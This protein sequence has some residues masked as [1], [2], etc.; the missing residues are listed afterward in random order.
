MRRSPRL[1]VVFTNYRLA[2]PMDPL[3]FSIANVLVGNKATIEGLEITLNGPELAFLGEAVVS[4]CGAPMEFTIDGKDCPMWSRIRVNA[5][6]RM[7]IGK[8]TGGGC[9]SYL[10]VHGGLPGVAE[11]FGSKATSPGVGV[12]GYQGRQLASGDLLTITKDIPP[13]LTNP[14]SLPQR[15]IPKYTKHWDLL[16]M[17][18]PYDD[19]YLLP[20][21]I[22]M[23]YNTKW[24]VS[25]NA[26]RGGIRLIGPK[27]KWARKDGGEGGAH[28][29][30]VVEYGYPV[31][32]LNWTGDDPCIFPVDCPDFGG[33]VSSTTIIKA[34]FWRL[35]Q[36]KAGDTMQYKRVSLQDALAM[37]RLVDNFISQITTA[38]SEE[39]FDEIMALDYSV[40]TTSIVSDK[41]AKAIVHK[42]DATGKQPL[43]LYRQ[44][45]DDYLLVEYGGDQHFDLNHRCR[46]TALTKALRDAKGD[47]SFTNGLVNSVGCCTSLLI[48]YDGTKIPQ[49]K[50]IDHLVGIESQLGD[51]SKAKVPSRMFKLP[52]TFNSHR[53][54]AAIKRYMETQRPY[55]SYL[56]DNMAF[57]AK[58]NGLERKDL[59]FILLNSK[60]MAV[61]VGFF[62]AL[63]LCL[64]VDPRQRMNCPKVGYKYLDIREVSFVVQYKANTYIR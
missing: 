18:G 9:R 1:H 13:G 62:A 58:N 30:N 4:L 39:S 60:L 37:R 14:L 2:G 36:M 34:D 6:Q 61:S 32:S 43:T 31:G 54:E 12:G 16:S 51:L 20:E 23:I 42:I 17:V 26:A 46:V 55:A 38:C 63:P 44:G 59:E 19:G 57:V 45:A 7:K 10:A 15:L 24:E 49:K 48:S 40:L 56:P 27:P 8:T 50:L 35:G 22:E 33:F 5:G 21:D 41:S 28:P 29:S 11:W 47:I 53:Q 64:P 52:I 3:A 25:H